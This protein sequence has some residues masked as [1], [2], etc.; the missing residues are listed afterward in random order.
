MINI[1]DY[2]DFRKYLTDYYEDKKK[3]NPNFSY[4]VIANKAG[5]K[6]R[7]FIYNIINGDKVLSK[8]NTF[9]ISQALVPYV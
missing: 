9:K 7:G 5:V 3:D 1:F 4:Q 8:S 2:S 6:N